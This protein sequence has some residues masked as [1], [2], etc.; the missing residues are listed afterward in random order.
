M[1]L[2]LGNIQNNIIVQLF[3]LSFHR[4]SKAVNDQNEVHS[5]TY[6]PTTEIKGLRTLL[7]GQKPS[8][9]PESNLRIYMC[10]QGCIYSYDV[11]WLFPEFNEDGN[12]PH[13]SAAIPLKCKGIIS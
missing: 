4:L 8:T 9:S 10:K 11:V 12:H 3:F 2:G 6:G 13:A 1:N 7:V 5:L